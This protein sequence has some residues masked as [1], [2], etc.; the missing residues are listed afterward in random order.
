MKEG[1]GSGH[2]VVSAGASCGR[3]GAEVK[4]E[5]PTAERPL[6]L[7]YYTLG[8]GGTGYP[9]YLVTHHSRAQPGHPGQGPAGGT[10]DLRFACA[11]RCER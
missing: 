2:P 6:R 5:H 7:A 9:R 11:L 10:V 8:A 1:G 3:S 4:V